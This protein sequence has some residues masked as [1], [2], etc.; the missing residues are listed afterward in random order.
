M[1]RRR[2]KSRKFNLKAFV[3][4]E[5][6]KLQKEALSGKLDDVSKVK[7]KIVDA[8]EE[9]STLEK[10]VDFIKALKIKENKLRRQNKKIVRQVK[11]LQEKRRILRRRVIKKI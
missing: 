8:G 6:R 3:L 9:A 4:R 10:D 7:A 1:R 2:T 5:A 11:K